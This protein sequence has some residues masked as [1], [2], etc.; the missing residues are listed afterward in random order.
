MAT[1]L[2]PN[3]EFAR[4]LE[5]ELFE[6]GVQPLDEPVIFGSTVMKL[7]GMKDDIGDVDLFVT[8]VAYARLRKVNHWHELRPAPHDPPYLEAIGFK[9]PNALAFHVFYAWTNRDPWLDVPDAVASAVRAGGVRHVRLPLVAS[10]KCEALRW[11]FENEV[12]IPGSP[13]EKHI[14]DLTTLMRHGI[15]PPEY[16]MAMA[17]ATGVFQ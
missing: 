14:A 5:R 15:M 2:T 10:W 11:C 12:T 6:L 8:P 9:P 16:D 3:L 7:Y 4:S 1:E 17:E 13:W